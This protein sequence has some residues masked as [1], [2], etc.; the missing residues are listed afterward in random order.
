MSISRPVP[1][2]G[3]IC[4]CHKPPKVYRTTD[5]KYHADCVPCKIAT[6]R[7]ST[8]TGAVTEFK[9]MCD[10]VRADRNM[11]TRIK[12]VGTGVQFR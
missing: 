4:V 12:L 6:P 3:C 9:R 1:F 10:T 5:Q 2:T 11:P 8:L 7:L